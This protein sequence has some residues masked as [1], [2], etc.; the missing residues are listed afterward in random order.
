MSP[1][2][3]CGAEMI[4]ARTRTGTAMPLDPAPVPEGNVQLTT[5]D[6][7]L[8]ATVLAGER[9]AAARAAGVTLHRPHHISCPEG[10]KWRRP[11]K[12]R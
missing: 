8:C 5:E 2:K 6:L 12:A 10:P 3:S 11:K 9:L 1:C 4:W 7:E